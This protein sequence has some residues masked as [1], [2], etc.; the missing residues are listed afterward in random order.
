MTSASPRRFYG[1]AAPSTQQQ[2]TFRRSGRSRHISLIQSSLP[3]KEP[4]LSMQEPPL[5]PPQPT[6]CTEYSVYSSHSL[7]LGPPT[8][9][10]TAVVP[11]LRSTQHTA[12]TLFVRSIQQSLFFYAAY[13]SHFYAAYSSHSF[14]TQQSLLS[15]L[16]PLLSSGHHLCCLKEGTGSAH[17][18]ELLNFLRFAP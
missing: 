11:L 17:V 15:P 6:P 9:L 5:T 16:P 4:D 10:R 1:V 2:P 7:L 18:S 13:S 14:S 8:Q 12:V 3:Y